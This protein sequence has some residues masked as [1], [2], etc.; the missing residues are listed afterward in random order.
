M[1]DSH[2]SVAQQPLASALRPSAWTLDTPRRRALA[3]AAP[4]YDIRFKRTFDTIAATAILIF[5]LPVLLISSML[6]KATS[7]GP[8]LFRQPRVGLNGKLFDCY[9]F[10]S[11]RVDCTDLLAARQTAVDDPRITRVGRWLRRFSIDEVPQL[12]NV[13]KGDMSLVGPRP[14]APMTGMGG[15]LLWEVVPEYDCRHAIRPGITGLAQISGCRGPIDHPEQIRRRVEYDLAYIENM[16]LLLDMKII[17]LTVAREVF[18]DHA[19]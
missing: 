17:W 9:K 18:S 5:V 15:K 19:F 3:I 1:P 13:L 10:R 12:F 2:Q 7:P 4:Q 16:S 14:H 11:M 6:V 8:I